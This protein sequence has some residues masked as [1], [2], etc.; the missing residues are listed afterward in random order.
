MTG[1]DVVLGV[2]LML[3]THAVSRCGWRVFGIMPRRGDS[4]A[5]LF[6]RGREGEREGRGERA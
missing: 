2:K 3:K 5:A 6:W 4:Q 1:A